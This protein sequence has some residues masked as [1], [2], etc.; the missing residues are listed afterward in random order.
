VELDKNTI[1]SDLNRINDFINNAIEYLES[2]RKKYELCANKIQDIFENVIFNKNVIVQTRVKSADSLREKIYR[3]NYFQKYNGDHEKVVTELTDLIGVRI[4][5]LLNYEEEEM[6]TQLSSNLKLDIGG[7]WSSKETQKK[8]S[9]KL[10]LKEQPQKQ[11]NGHSI[12][13]V[14]GKW[15]DN[16]HKCTINIELQIKSMVHF[17]W[18]EMEH[19][20]FYKNYEC[21]IADSFYTEEMKNINSDL[22]VIDKRLHG[23]KMQFN[24]ELIDHIYEIKEMAMSMLYNTYNEQVSLLF[25]CKIDLREAYRLIVDI[26][27]HKCPTINVAFDRLKKLTDKVLNVQSLAGYI[28]NITNVDNDGITARNAII[29]KKIVELLKGRDI[30]WVTFYALYVAIITETQDTDNFTVKIEAISNNLRSLVSKF[31]DTLE[32]MSVD[33]DIYNKYKNSIYLGIYEAFDNKISFFTNYVLIDEYQNKVSEF[34]KA[35]Q[36]KLEVMPIEDLESCIMQV[37]LY[38]SCIVSLVN[39]GYIDSG[40]VYELSEQNKNSMALGFEVNTELIEEILENKMERVTNDEWN[41][42]ISFGKEE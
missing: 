2:N 39:L 29:A 11:K 41:K 38:V 18:G 37:K 27:F 30:F 24:K 28:N 10:F 3:K 15:I 16:E 1:E 31:E 4:I 23:L 5:C 9:I 12:Y 42:L 34:I 6:F 35:T 8:D 21:I 7:D 17:F 22:E 36:S 13:R 33:D 40:S 20:L 25:N 32:N 19:K 14:D 26:Y